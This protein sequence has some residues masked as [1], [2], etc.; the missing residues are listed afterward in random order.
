LL[1]AAGKL[2]R[3]TVTET[4]KPN[5]RKNV[6]NQGITMF[7]AY[8]ADRERVSHVLS[9]AHMREEGITLENDSEISP[10]RRDGR[11]I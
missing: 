1:L 10:L 5:E 2:R 7:A 9:N 11:N 4:L 6:I 3:P 8:S